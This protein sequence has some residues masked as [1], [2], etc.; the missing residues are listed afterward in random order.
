M[1]ALKL[2]LLFSLVVLVLVGGLLV[3][4]SLVDFNH[5]KGQ[6]ENQVLQTSAALS[7]A[8]KSKALHSVRLVRAAR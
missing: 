2:L 7:S 1:K 6:I 8:F 4:L 3:T 5:Y